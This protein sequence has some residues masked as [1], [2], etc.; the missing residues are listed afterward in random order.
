[1]RSRPAA[2]LLAYFSKPFRESEV[3]AY[4][5]PWNAGKRA[6]F[7]GGTEENAMPNPNGLRGQ[8]K[9]QGDLRDP[10]GGTYGTA[11]GS[12]NKGEQ[13]HTTPEGFE[14]RKG[15]LGKNTGR[16]NGNV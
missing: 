12:E 11:L 9:Q 16:R 4:A 6:A 1:L 7:I 13:D 15:P 2:L 5:M 8:D 10:K 14:H 3:P